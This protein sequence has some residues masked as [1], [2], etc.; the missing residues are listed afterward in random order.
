MT[1][2]NFTEFMTDNLLE[3]DSLLFGA[4]DISSDARRAF[5]RRD[6]AA[7]I[8]ADKTIRDGIVAAMIYVLLLEDLFFASRRLLLFI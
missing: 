8:L 1:G 6:F 3:S 4:L 7:S 5:D 2:D